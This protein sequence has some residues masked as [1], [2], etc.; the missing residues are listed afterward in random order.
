MTRKVCT[1]DPIFVLHLIRSESGKGKKHKIHSSNDPQWQRGTPLA[2]S[3]L[4]GFTCSEA[5]CVQQ[6][7]KAGASVRPA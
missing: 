2:I 5:Y 4:L 7:W 1:N 3:L 6:E